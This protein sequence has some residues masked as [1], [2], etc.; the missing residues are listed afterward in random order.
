MLLAIALGVLT[1]AGAFAMLPG[2]EEKAVAMISEG[3]T[4]EALKL[5]EASRADGEFTSHERSL[6]AEL[7][8]DRGELAHAAALLEHLANDPVHAGSALPRL[9]ALYGQVHDQ[10]RQLEAARR[11]YD[12]RPTQALYDELRLLYRLM[13]EWQGELSLL[14]RAIKAGHASSD[15]I[16][17]WQHLRNVKPDVMAAAATWHAPWFTFPSINLP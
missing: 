6:L 11:L 5:L 10:R 9:T 16:L 4:N 2:T 7:Y 15:D 17:R 12:L 3:R 8:L 14:D 1:I 13:G